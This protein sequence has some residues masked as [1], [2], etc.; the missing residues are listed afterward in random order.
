VVTATAVLETG[1]L[2]DTQDGDTI[3]RRF[4]LNQAQLNAT[5]SAAT[6]GRSLATDEVALSDSRSRVPYLNQAILRRPVFSEQ[7]PLLDD[8]DDYYAPDRS[9]A[10][11]LSAWPTPDLTTRG[12]ALIGHP[13][14]LVRPGSLAAP[15]KAGDEVDVRLATTAEELAKAELIAIEGYP[16]DE[17]TGAPPNSILGAGLVDGPVRVR[18]GY[19]DGRPVSVAS[20]HVAFGVVNLC[21]AA[22]L[23]SERRNGVWRA[24]VHARLQDGPN[25]PAVAFTSD[26]SRPGLQRMEFLPVT[27]FTLWMRPG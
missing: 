14:F 11:V 5:L 22:T 17:A 26:F 2:A 23:P 8:I 19:H 4:L 25:L 20:S 13:V 18:V 24:L 21:L 12:W 27:R 15:E 10:M 16:L 1:W 9:P 7:D 6:A 3:V